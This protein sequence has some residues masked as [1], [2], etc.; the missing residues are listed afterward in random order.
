[1]AIYAF[2][3]LIDEQWSCFD[4]LLIVSVVS[5]SVSVSASLDRLGSPKGMSIA[6]WNTT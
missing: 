1:M 3:E 6:Y 4:S 2:L 5:C